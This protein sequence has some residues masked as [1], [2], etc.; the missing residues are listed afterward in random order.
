MAVQLQ[1][2]GL[3]SILP[4]I[5]N[6]VI[7]YIRNP[8]RFPINKYAQY[9]QTP[10]VR[11]A[12]WYIDPDQP[13]RIVSD[14][15]F[16]WA[17]GAPRP[18]G[19]QNQMP[20]ELKQFTTDRRDYPWTLGD[21]AVEN[22]EDFSG[23][24]LREW[25]AAMV[26]SQAMTNRTNRT[27]STLTNSANWG[28]N[29]ASAATLNGA[30]NW[31]LASSDPTSPYYLAIK[32]SLMAAYNIITLSTNSVVKLDDL[33]LIISPTLATTMGNTSEIYDYV[34]YG[35]FSEGAQR[36]EDRDVGG[37]RGVPDELY[38]IKVIV[39][40]TP[41]VNIRPNWA[42]AT[43]GT[44][45]AY[46]AASISAGQ[47]AFCWPQATAVLM[48]RIGGVEGPYGAPSF[49]TYQIYFYG[50]PMQVEQFK[51]PKDRL[52]EGHVSENFVEVLAAPASGFCITSCM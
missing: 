33:R 34:K 23:H 24:D 42:T 2:L 7:S 3:R 18:K 29:T 37:L 10:L 41:L 38:G 14:A 21:M 1:Y 32:K 22:I 48:S 9:V 16:A 4:D 11:G 47:R 46:N 50:A 45:P 35:P 40:D 44:A 19:Y 17:D 30:G 6:Y 25:Y 52:T 49:S 36:G 13:V 27:T 8:K 51:E 43:G 15:E 12:Y 28:A 5:S 26:A 31:T 20:G 39:E